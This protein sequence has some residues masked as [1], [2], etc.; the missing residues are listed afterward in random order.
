[1]AVIYQCKHCNQ[2][3]GQITEDVVDTKKLGWD[4]L[5]PEERKEMINYQHNGD[6]HMKVTCENCQDALEQNPHYH[7]LDYFIH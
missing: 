3:I 6:V 4:Q 7:E 1:M 2:T 5:S